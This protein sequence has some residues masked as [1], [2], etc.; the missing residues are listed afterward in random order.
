MLTPKIFRKAASE[1]LREASVLVGVFGVLD[2]LLKP[3]AAS[4]APWWWIPVALLFS[5]FLFFAGLYFEAKAESE[6]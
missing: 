4:A 1:Y 5:I 3:E 2:Y 6:D